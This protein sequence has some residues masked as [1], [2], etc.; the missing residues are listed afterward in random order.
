MSDQWPSDPGERPPV[1]ESNGASGWAPP[2]AGAGPAGGW[3]PPEP[4]PSPTPAVSP[5]GSSWPRPDEVWPTDPAG[6]ATPPPPR[7]PRGRQGLLFAAIVVLVALLAAGATWLLLGADTGDEQT[8]TAESS[9]TT[10][11][12]D[13]AT[14]PTTP[15]VPPSTTAPAPTVP[16]DPAA[17]QAEVRDLQDFVEAER[18]LAFRTDV[19]VEV[20]D[21]EAFEARL[22]EGLE[23]EAEDIELQQRLLDALGL[24][25]PGTD[26]L[27]VQRQLL[28][29]GVLGWYDPEIDE[30]VVR[31]DALTP[32]T[33]Q[34]I[35]HEL[36]H[37]L[38]DQWFELHRPEYDERTDEV[39]TGLVALLEGDA[40]RIED[41][42][43]ATL[44]ADEA[45]ERAREEARFALEA[46][47]SGVPDILVSMLVFP[48]D[49]GRTLVDEIVATGGLGALDR[50]IA[51]PP[52]TTEQ[53]LVPDAWFAREPAAAV[54][55]PDAAGEVIDEGTFGML[56]TQLLLEEAVRPGV[57][58]AAAEGW[59]GDAYVAWETAD[60]ATCVRVETHVDTPSD[61]LELLQGL[62][63]YVFDR[64][65]VEVSQIGP[66][67]VRTEGCTQPQPSG[68]GGTPRP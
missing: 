31:G 38:D 4:T 50:A 54:P 1:G 60:G 45:A 57:A 51:D 6:P 67:E 37:A 49:D 32:Y 10:T 53:V 28:G 11:P 68:G 18:G 44:D 48:Y 13:P 41:A 33:R 5:T 58:A 55:I 59:H 8:S 12:D 66:L 7:E 52:T 9:T 20:L 14:S 16:L 29:E 61:V 35:V 26:L 3:A 23:E 2:G 21:D 25:E 62:E 19:V 47:L 22:L 17:L 15:T 30:L 65:N 63:Q 39:S 34:T 36:V 27:A 24:L 43:V 42:W 40:T 46:D 64:P 56:M